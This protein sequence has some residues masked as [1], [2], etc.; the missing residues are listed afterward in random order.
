L[1][2]SLF[3]YAMMDDKSSLPSNPPDLSGVDLSTLHIRPMSLV[4]IERVY[5]IDQLS[6][7]MPWPL[8]SYRYELTENKASLSHVAELIQEDGTLIVVGMVVTWLIMDEAHIATIAVHPNFRQ[9]GIGKKLL[10]ASLQEAIRGGAVSATL[11]VRAGNQAA[12]NMYTSFGFKVAGRRPRYYHDTQEDAIIMTVK[13]LGIPYL[14]WLR[15]PE[16]YPPP[17]AED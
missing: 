11:E 2:C 8:S 15:A 5:L 17:V 13:G 9:Q 14:N 1:N 12:A 4:D 3:Y 7:S 6:F 10:V 16:H